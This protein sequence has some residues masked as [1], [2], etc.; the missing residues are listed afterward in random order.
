MSKRYEHFTTRSRDFETLRDLTIR[1]LICDLISYYC[2]WAMEYIHTL[3][4]AATWNFLDKQNTCF[5]NYK[6]FDYRFSCV[7]WRMTTLLW[8]IRNQIT[9]YTLYL[10]KY[11]Y[12]SSSSTSTIAKFLTTI[13]ILLF[14]FL[15]GWF[16]TQLV[17]TTPYI[18]KDFAKLEDAIG[19]SGYG[20]QSYFLNDPH[21][22]IPTIPRQV[23]C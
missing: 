7:L 14:W 19:H 20:Y 15:Y 1:R 12:C 13:P 5:R 3:V 11:W 8:S 18:Q 23:K 17:A 22:C 10:S 2:D 6:H 4:T 16:M 9:E 21:I